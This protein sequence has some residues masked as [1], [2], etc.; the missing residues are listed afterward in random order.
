MALDRASIV[1]G[2]GHLLLGE[3]AILAA[4]DIVVNFRDDTEDTVANGYG[5]IDRRR[6]DRKI[7][8]TCTP[9][10]WDN[11]STL[12][13]HASVQIG[14]SIYGATDVALSILPRNGALSGLTFANVAV[15]K[16]P[17][18]NYSAT[19][20]PLGSMTFTA[21]LANNSDPAVDASYFTTAAVTALPPPDLTKIRNGIYTA[22]WGTVLQNFGSEDGFELDVDLGLSPVTVDGHGTI[23]MFLTGLTASCRV[24]PIGLTLASVAGAMGGALGASLAKHALIIKNNAGATVATIPNCQLLSS[25]GQWGNDKKRLGALEFRSVRTATDGALTPLWTLA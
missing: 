23:D 25:S 21:L 15:T 9:L 6:K 11:L 22:S 13:P 20:R 3:T 2:P 24:T 8:I 5:L 1:I 14:E 17:G 10:H 7:E 18:V 4:D 19:K 16:M 12:L